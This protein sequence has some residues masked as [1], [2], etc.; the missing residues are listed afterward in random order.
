MQ[1]N[2]LNGWPWLLVGLILAGCSSQYVS[3][4]A[5]TETSN[6]GR[7]SLKQDKGPD[8][9]LAASDIN[10]TTPRKEPLS[11]HGNK[12]P[13]TVNGKKYHIMSSALGFKEEG[14]ASW[15]GQKFH[16]HSTSNGET[17]DMY[18]IS[19][20]HKTLP[21]PTWVRVTNLDNGKSIDVRVNDRGPFHGGRIIDLSYAGAVKLGYVDKGTA[22][23]RVEV[24]EGDSLDQS[25]YF[26]QV[27]AFSSKDSAQN[28]QKRLKN[29]VDYKVGVYKDNFYRVRIGPVK[30]DQAIAIQQQY[31]GDEFGKPLLVAKP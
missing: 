9:P 24:L 27:G 7:Y 11:K 5:L 29:E 26:V 23:V 1:L 21:L 18:K 2:S 19:A 15:Y 10:T 30:Y 3:H 6:A 22:R 14:L 16:G 8:Q 25:A 4:D 13:Y 28:L 20:A 17:F 31:T 12:S